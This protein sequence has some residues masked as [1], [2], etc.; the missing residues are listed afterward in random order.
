MPLLSRNAMTARTPASP[1]RRAQRTRTALREALLSLMHER[2]WDDIDVQQVC[3]RANVGRSTFYNHF[4]NKEAL[5]VGGFDDLRG[6]LKQQ[7]GPGGQVLGLIE[8]AHQN[9][10]LFRTLI[11]RRSGFAVQQRFR[12]MLVKLVDEELTEWPSQAPRA[13]A[14]RWVAGALFELL[15]WWVESRSPMQPQQLHELFETLCHRGRLA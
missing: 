7:R 5:L 6:L 11:G 8:H 2:A 1:D 12:D 15:I 10:R 9:R 13:A 4:P 3:E 14:V